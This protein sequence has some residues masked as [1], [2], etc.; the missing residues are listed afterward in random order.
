[1]K[2]YSKYSRDN[3]KVFAFYSRS[4]GVIKDIRFWF[5]LENSHQNENLIKLLKEKQNELRK[6]KPA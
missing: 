1:M 3:T 2:K 4:E 5:P 6:N